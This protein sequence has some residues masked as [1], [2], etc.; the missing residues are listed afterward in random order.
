MSVRRADRQVFRSVC[1]SLGL[2]V[3]SPLG[4]F[5]KKVDGSRE[6]KRKRASLVSAGRKEEGE[7]PLGSSKLDF[8]AAGCSGPL[9]RH[10]ND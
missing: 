8:S 10:L 9:G 3:V 4:L 5:L 2:S 1:L 7:S 6:E